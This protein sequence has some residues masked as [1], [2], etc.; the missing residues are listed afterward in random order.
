MSAGQFKLC[1][2]QNLL[3]ELRVSR[4]KSVLLTY[5]AKLH[6]FTLSQPDTIGERSDI[7]DG[8][9]ASSPAIALYTT[10]R[11]MKAAL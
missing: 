11:S 3:I 8:S 10:S 7:G 5:G 9:A 6:R 4:M 1:F 2:A